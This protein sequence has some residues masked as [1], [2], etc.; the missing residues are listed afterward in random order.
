MK[1]RQV[2]FG[3]DDGPTM[4]TVEISAEEATLLYGF[5]GH[6]APARVTEASNLEWGNL[7]SDLATDL[8]DIGIRLYDEG[9]PRLQFPFRGEDS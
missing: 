2:Q 7:F 8:G 1:L 9:W 3:D 6:T 5:L 4:L